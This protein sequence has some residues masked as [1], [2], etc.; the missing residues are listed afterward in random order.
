MPSSAI[1]LMKELK[2]EA[3]V[4]WRHKGNAF[5]KRR[6][7]ITYFISTHDSN[8]KVHYLYYI[9]HEKQLYLLKSMYYISSILEQVLLRKIFPNTSAHSSCRN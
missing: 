8:G 1:V 5:I 3:I 2:I 7:K 4:L 9:W 6:Y